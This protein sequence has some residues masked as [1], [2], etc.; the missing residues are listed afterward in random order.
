M[1]SSCNYMLICFQNV[2]IKCDKLVKICCLHTQE[3][4][5]ATYA[6][7]EQRRYETEILPV[8]VGCDSTAK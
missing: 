5:L 4:T 3:F 1:G 2:A 8:I 7:P 6:Q